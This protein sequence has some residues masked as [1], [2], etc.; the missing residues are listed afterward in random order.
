MSEEEVMVANKAPEEV[1]TEEQYNYY[2][3]QCKVALDSVVAKISTLLEMP[4]PDGKEKI[5]FRI[6][7]RIKAFEDVLEKCD[8]RGYSK[9][10]KS[11]RDNIKDVAGVRI[12]TKY[13]DEPKKVEELLRQIPGLG[14]DDTEDYITNPK[15]SGYRALHIHANI[16]V[17]NP[18]DRGI[19]V[20]PVEIQLMS[21]LFCSFA[22]R[23]HSLRYKN[24]ALTEEE[25]QLMF[26][27]WNGIYDNELRLIKLRDS[28]KSRQQ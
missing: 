16:E 9:T 3:A 27:M 21:G 15:E 12:V 1:C 4:V 26:E 18:Y 28:M 11:I 2:A 13:I 10:I 22:K 14:L 17:F 23:E 7:K 20:I 24:S 6:E 8:G 25:S 5:S 19:H